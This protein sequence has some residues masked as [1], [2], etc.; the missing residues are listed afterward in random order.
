MAVAFV[1][2]SDSQDVPLFTQHCSTAVLL[3]GKSQVK[4]PPRILYNTIDLPYCLS[5]L[6]SAATEDLATG[7]KALGASA[8][9]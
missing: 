5:C 1:R 4:H 2:C 8:P 3:E 6:F 9:P 7:S